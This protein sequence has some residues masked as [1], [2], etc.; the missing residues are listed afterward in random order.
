MEIYYKYLVK[1]GNN[2]YWE[3][4]NNNR[5]IVIQS[6]GN[7]IIFDEKSNNISK[8]KTMAYYP[9]NNATGNL[10]STTNK[11]NNILSNLSFNT[12]NNGIYNILSSNLYIASYQS[13]SSY[14]NKSIDLS[15]WRLTEGENEDN[16]NYFNNFSSKD[17]T[18]ELVNGDESINN[19]IDP[20]FEILEL[21]Q[22]IQQED[23][24]IIVT[25]FLPF[26]IEKKEN[27]NN[28][29]NLNA[30]QSE[31]NINLKYAFSLFDDKLINLL[32]YSLK[33]MKYCEVYWV[34]MLR[35]LEDYPEKIQFEICENLE[36]QKIFVVLPT[37][38]ELTNFQIYINQ[39][40]YPLYN[41]LEIDIN[42]NIFQNQE[43]YYTSLLSVNKTFAKIIN[44]CSS[45]IFQKK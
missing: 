16:N 22:N 7:L 40:L 15:N 14:Q 12:G 33:T 36:N 44:S 24:I 34:G 17:I 37:K 31:S 42:N 18:Y 45:M 6:P 1:E 28:I 29:D 11:L 39:I 27:L 3:Q 41:N 19:D 30:S 10:S 32:L 5:H 21:G 25:T 20:H 38:K 43:N 8:I 9:M 2:I 23:K 4:L 35:G 26:I 13:L